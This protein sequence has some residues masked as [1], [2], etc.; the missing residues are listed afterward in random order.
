MKVNPNQSK[1]DYLLEANKNHMNNIA[2]SFDN[3]KITYEELHDRIEK[4]AKILYKKGIRKGD[5]IGVCT[6]NTPES[7]YLLYALDV[8]GTTVV[9]LSPF[10]NK[11]KI[12]LDL[13]LT[14]P[15]MVITVDMN[16]SNIK[17]YEK[18]L[19]FSTI[20]Y[21]PVESL[22]DTKKRILYNLFQVK[23]GNFKFNKNDYLK[24]VLKMDTNGIKLEKNEY[25]DGQLTDIMF[26]GGSTGVHKGVDLDGS[27]LNYV[28]EGMKYM[29]PENFFEGQTYL[30]N[31][32]FGHMVYGR[33][34]LHIAL[35]NNM[36]YAL[37]L[38]AMPEDFYD[39]IVRTEAFAAVGGPP[40]WGTL[41]EKTEHGFKIRDNLKKGSL[42]NLH[43]ATSGGE[44][45]KKEQNDMINEALKYCG[46]PTVLG[47][48]LGATEAWSVVTLNSGNCYKDNSIG[49]PIDTLD[50]KLIN[51]ETGELAKDG[52][53]GLLYVSGKSV[54]MGYHNNKEE[55]DKVIS[56]DEN[57]KKWC[58]LGDYLMKG[59]DGNLYYVGRQKRNHVCGCENIYPEQLETL[60]NA[61]DE[62]LESIVTFIPDDE[63]QYVPIFHIALKDNNVDIDKFENKLEKIILKNMS[64]SWLPRKINYYDKPLQRML[65]SKL[66][67]SYY[68]RLD[69]QNIE[70][71]EQKVL[72]K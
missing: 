43:L 56:Y 35:T 27:G 57:G 6:L 15:K 20:L 34:I 18:A 41:I 71:N 29:Y 26:T 65:N 47:D 62:V 5:V 63:L 60:I 33:C 72:K 9:G 51:P 25:K 13:E 10:D 38:K 1:Y 11:E 17:E 7:V 50:Y 52:E 4:Y 12:K 28:I 55:T 45:K 58:N 54:M 53:K 24:N 36:N 32:P 70:K 21:S 44:A 16:Y 37:T 19:N 22:S 69:I 39:E 59:S 8:I 14:K 3:R 30:G 49:L 48:G 68:E 61:Q 40:H 67:I 66:D 46:S 2:L 31:I 64:Q 42:S 23:N